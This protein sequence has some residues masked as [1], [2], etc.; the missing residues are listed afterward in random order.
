M[1]YFTFVD[2]Y[3][4]RTAPG[5]WD[6]PLNAVTN[7]AFII[8][9]LWVWPRVAGLAGARVLAINLF[10]IGVGSGLFHT[11]AQR[12]AAMADVLPI[13]TFILIYIY[14]A[15]R[16]ILGGSRLISAIAVVAAFGVLPLA[17]AAFAMAGVPGGAAGYLPVPLLILLYALAARR[18]AP[19]TSR[20]LATGA[21]ILLVSLT[22]RTLD[23]P[24]CATIPKGTHFLW[25]ILNGIMLT[26]MIVVYRAHMLATRST[27]R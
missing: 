25:H 20:G 18:M 21:V 23:E 1:D 11:F 13:V 12:W 8:G 6:E 26:Y 3:C 15:T 22:F 19:D 7:L 4:E 5:L 27:P 10:V 17:S 2:G 9:A 14:L 16:D 24:L